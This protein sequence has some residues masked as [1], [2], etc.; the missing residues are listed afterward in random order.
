M[1]FDKTYLQKPHCVM[2]ENISSN[3]TYLQLILVFKN[4]DED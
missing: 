4:K 2:T 1:F 3:K